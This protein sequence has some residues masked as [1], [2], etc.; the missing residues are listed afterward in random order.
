[1][2]NVITK[3]TLALILAVAMFM[4]TLATSPHVEAATIKMNKTKVTIGVGD[5][6]QLKVSGTSKKAKWSTSNKKVATV[7]KNGKVTGKKK[8]TATITAKIGK[9]SYKC[10]VTVKNPALAKKTIYVTNGHSIK[11]DVNYYGG[12]VTWSVA[13]GEVA[14]IDKNGNVTGKKPGTTRYTA[15]LK[16]GKVLKGTITVEKPV[17]KITGIIRT[18]ETGYSNKWIQVEQKWQVKMKLKVSTKQDIKWT[19]EYLQYSTERIKDPDVLFDNC[20]DGVLKNGNITLYRGAQSAYSMTWKITA[21]LEDG[22][23]FE[24]YIFHNKDTHMNKYIDPQDY[25]DKTEKML[26]KE[27]PGAK[28]Y[29]E[30]DTVYYVRNRDISGPTPGNGTVIDRENIDFRWADEE[31]GACSYVRIAAIDYNNGTL[32]HELTNPDGTKY[33]KPLTG[34]WWNISNIA[35]TQDSSSREKDTYAAGA[36]ESAGQNGS[37]HVTFVSFHDY[38]GGEKDNGGTLNDLHGNYLFTEG[39]W[40]YYRTGQRKCVKLTCWSE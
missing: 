12:K 20:K 37:I 6:Y 28:Y 9:K 27:A 15:T 11:A 16:N 10:K 18:D 4:T 2:K 23:Q 40:A 5:T 7:N 26:K 36:I 3:R 21:T 13:D 8:G 19:A 30:K 14:S 17:Q 31:S 22:N 1:M 29:H 35:Y 33:D 32:D 39:V 25:Y 34:T 24:F 38:Y